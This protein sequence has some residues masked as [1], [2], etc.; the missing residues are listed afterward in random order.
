MSRGLRL[1]LYDRTCV[2]RTGLGLSRA[3]SAG[4]VLYAMLR[5]SDGAHGARTWEEGLAWL[6]S[7]RAE[8]PI[9]EVQYW[10]HGKWGRLLLAGKALDAAAL[11]EG[12]RHHGALGALRA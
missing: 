12:H 8:Q 7:F 10:G 3:W 1:I 11:R 9:D 5:R 6:S 2:N 4:S